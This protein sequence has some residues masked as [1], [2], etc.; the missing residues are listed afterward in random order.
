MVNFL[1]AHVNLQE[2]HFFLVS[3]KDSTIFNTDSAQYIYHIKLQYPK[4]YSLDFL[5]NLYKK[6]ENN[7]IQGI[8]YNELNLSLHNADIIYLYDNDCIFLKI[9]EDF[10][11]LRISIFL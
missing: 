3:F 6:A 10:Y 2:K 11:I 9:L 1:N 7:S 8:G 4:N 5:V